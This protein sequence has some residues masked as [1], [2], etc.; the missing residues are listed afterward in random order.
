MDSRAPRE[1][2]NDGKRQKWIAATLCV[3]AERYAFAPSA[4]FYLNRS[5][6]L[7]LSELRTTQMTLELASKRKPPVL[8]YSRQQCG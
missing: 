2:D 6:H 4:S 7:S 8:S 3:C 1:N 5:S